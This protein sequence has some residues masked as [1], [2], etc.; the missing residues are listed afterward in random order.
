MA[1]IPDKKLFLGARLKR[2][3]RELDLTQARM[4]EELGVS[5]SYL[6]LLER[7]QRP[8]TAQV[9]LR[10]A[11]A[12]DLDLRS[13]SNDS[14]AAGAQGLEEVFAD[15]LFK[16]LRPARHEIAE[17]AEQAPIAS[18]A[19]VRL[20]RAYVDSRR[21]AD[22]G[23]GQRPEEGGASMA[24]G[25]SDWVRDLIQNQ[26]NYFAELDEVAE[27]YGQ[28]LSP[29]PQDFAAAAAA[30]LAERFGV[31]VTIAPASLLTTMARRYDLHRKRLFLSEA[32]SNAGRSFG[33]AYQL[34]ALEQGDLIEAQIDRASPPDAA[35]RNLA[36]VALTNY[37]AAAMIMPYEAFRSALEASGYDIDLACA[38]FG[39]S[40]EQACH[41]ITTLARPGA[42]GLAF[43]MIRVDAA[44]NTSKRYANAAFPFSRFAGVCPRWNLHA[45]FRTP[46]RTVTQ[47]V[48]TLAGERYFTL[49]RTVPRI[50]GA[51]G[52]DD[53]ELAI[54]LG[55]ELK[56]AAQLIHAGGLDLA[57]PRVTPIGPA[58]RICERADC[59]QRA[60]EPLG[61]TLA[62]DRYAKA[63]T[64]YPFEAF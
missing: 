4:A 34:A 46:G 24:V 33:L 56:H 1:N 39:V 37:M 61:R 12:Y 41:R 62:I 7:N 58:C 57:N 26:R 53:S 10:L 27:V 59:A 5:P 38:R 22:L 8:V 36:R 15:Q 21:M 50:A 63:I 28:T 18:E 31:K 6:N 47:I 3:R 11:E 30:R 45:A 23:A 17:L 25:A 2:L 51:Q 35:T 43:F 13:L 40:Y 48:E 32:L 20:Y 64:P 29:A 44:G 54:G 55:C 42:R 9:L 52:G 16:G 60:A 49:S 14:D 19:I